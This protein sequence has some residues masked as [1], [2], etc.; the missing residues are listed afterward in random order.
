MKVYQYALPV[1]DTRDSVILYPT[2]VYMKDFQ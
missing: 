1:K 2:C